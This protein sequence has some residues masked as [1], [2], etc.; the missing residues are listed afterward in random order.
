MKIA[1]CFQQ[2]INNNNKIFL[3]LFVLINLFS[4][5][6]CQLVK[7]EEEENC[8]PKQFKLT[9]HPTLNTSY[10]E[11][12]ENGNLE[13]HDCPDE[14]IFNINILG[15]EEGGRT[16]HG[17]FQSEG[18]IDGQTSLKKQNTNSN[19]TTTNISNQTNNTDEENVLKEP[20]FQA[21]D[22][23]CSGAIPLTKLGAPVMC[24]PSISSCP[25]GFL[26][27]LHQRTG[28]SYCCQASIESIGPEGSSG[29]IPLCSGLQVTF[30][31]TFSGLPKTCSLTS[32]SGCPTG[33]GC[34]L[35]DG[36]FTRC[37][38][39]D[40]GCPANSAGFVHPTTGSHVQ[41]NSADPLSCPNGFIC[42]QSSMFNTGICC[43][44][45]SNAPIDVCGGESPL[46]RPNPCSASDPCPMGYSCRNG[47]CCPSK[48]VCPVGA[49]L[50]G[51]TSCSANGNPCPN[52]FQCVTNNGHQ[53]CCP[54]PEHVCSLPNDSGI[55]CPARVLSPISRFYF[56]S[57][58][59]SCR[60]FQFSQCGGNANNFDSLEQ[61]EGFCLESQCPD[62]GT[63]LRAG[64]SLAR[65]SPGE[66]NGARLADTCPAHYVCV[67]PLFGQHNFVCC[68]SPE[69]VCREPVAA[70][71]PCF[72]PFL[73]IQRFHFNQNKGQCEAFQYYG[74][75]GTGNNFITRSQC[76]MQC[77]PSVQNSC[78]GVAPLNDPGDYVQRCNDNSQC[79]S[80]SWCNQKSYCCPHGETA[81]S[82]QKSIGHT[83]LS[84]RPGT[85]WYY[86]S[87]TDSCLPF[88]YSGCGGTPNRFSEREACEYM[89]LN[90]QENLNNDGGD[91]CPRGMAPLLA[92]GGRGGGRNSKIQS[93]R[94]PLN[95]LN[96]AGSSSYKKCPEGSS[97]VQ[98]INNKNSQKWICCI[99]VAQCP[100]GRNAYLIPNSDS[101]VACVPE[102]LL[103]E[104]GE[105][106]GENFNKNCPSKYSCMQSANVPGFYMCCSSNNYNNVGGGGRSISNT[107]LPS[108]SKIGSFT[109]AV[110]SAVSAAKK[111]AMSSLLANL[112]A[113]QQQ[114]QKHQ[115]HQ[116][117]VLKCPSGLLSNGAK[118]V[119]NQIQACPLGYLCI[120]DNNIASGG[121]G[122]CCK[123]QPK[124]TRK[125]R[126]PVYIA[127]KQVLTCGD[128]EAGCPEGSRC[129]RSTLSGIHICCMP[130]ESSAAVGYT[131]GSSSSSASSSSN[132]DRRTIRRPESSLSSSSSS[133]ASTSFS[134]VP[135]I[136]PKCAKDGALPFFALGSRVPQQCTADRD[137]ECPEEFECEMGTDEQFYCCPAW[138][139]CPAGA[140]PFFVEG[141]RKPLGCN[142]M[143]N[144]CPEGY[145]CEGSKDRAICCRMRANKLQCP[146]GRSPYLYGKRPVVC[147][148]TSN[149]RI[150]PTGFECTPSQNGGGQ[151]LCCSTPENHAPECVAGFGYLDPSTG[152]NQICDPTLETC[153][154]GYRCKRSTLANT[155]VCCSL[156]LDN[157]YDGYCPPGQI[158]LINSGQQLQQEDFI[159]PTNCHQVLNPCP[160]INLIGPPYQCIYSTEKQDSFCCASAVGHQRFG[161][162][163]NNN[164]N[165]ANVAAFP[166]RGESQQQQQQNQQMQ[167][168]LQ[169]QQHW[170]QQ[171]HHRNSATAAQ[172]QAAQA[173]AALQASQVAAAQQQQQQLQQ[174]QQVSSTVQG[175]GGSDGL[176]NNDSLM[177]QQIAAANQMLQLQ[178]QQQNGGV[179][180][181]SY[182]QQSQQ[183]QQQ[184]L[185]QQNIQA[186]QQQ[187]GGGGQYNQQIAQQQ[188]TQQQQQS[189]QPKQSSS[190]SSNNYP[191]SQA[192]ISAAE[193]LASAAL[194]SIYA[195]YGTSK[196]SS[197][198]S[199]S[200]SSSSSLFVA[201]CP[202][203]SRPLL[204]SSTGLGRSCSTWIKC[205]SSFTCYSNFPDGRNAHCCTTVPLD[206]RIVFKANTAAILADEQQQYPH[207]NS[208]YSTQ[209][210]TQNNG[211]LNVSTGVINNGG[212]SIGKCPSNMI[213]IG[214]LCKR[215]FFIGQPGCETDQ[216]CTARSNG[217]VCTRG[218][219]ACPPPLLIHES[220]CVLQCP[221]AM[222]TIAGRCYDLGSI[223]FMDSVDNRENG[224]IGGFCLASVVPEEQCNVKNAY[225][226]EK[227]LT[228]QCTP[229]YELRIDD[230]NNRTEKG[231]CMEVEGS[232]FQGNVSSKRLFDFAHDEEIEEQI[233]NEE[234]IFFKNNKN[235]NIDD[236]P[237][238][239]FF[240]IEFL[241]DL[242]EG[243]EDLNN[244]TSSG[245]KFV[246]ETTTTQ[247]I[248][249]D[250][251]EEDEEEKEEEK[252]DEENKK[253]KKEEEK[254]KE[255]DNEEEKKRM[256]KEEGNDV[257]KEEREDDEEKEDKEEKDG[258][259][260]EKEDKKK[261]G[262]LTE[263]IL[264]IKNIKKDD[265]KQKLL[266]L[267]KVVEKDEET[268]Q[269]QKQ[270]QQEKKQKHLHQ[271]KQQQNNKNTTENKILTKHYDE[272]QILFQSDD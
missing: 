11:C 268:L 70:G 166:S 42:T 86:D 208:Q 193:N 252:E 184:Q 41:C 246:E 100:N 98:S 88:E 16:D 143:A 159:I 39:R 192:A 71:V 109:S 182:Q 199:P 162:Y 17:E 112:N 179:S 236:A 272:K 23:I 34:N 232:R 209:Y 125:G 160:S 5:I 224:T 149:K 99:S 49:P 207:F 154:L 242:V 172:Q 126:K 150:C 251:I 35:V 140:S 173:A 145:T 104:G 171:F 94:Q 170:Q 111:R 102:A 58:T 243:E 153:P 191:Y 66:Q 141:S 18:L 240:E 183:P 121:K 152:R 248:Q 31:E 216:Q 10:F 221:E 127:P 91:E 231:I 95:N 241:N 43:S 128:E 97:C 178:Q 61:C 69:Q 80:G 44:D 6:F 245:S 227:S 195:N 161:N 46:P 77:V 164:N 120:G 197:S 38:G 117:S 196:N 253:V 163:F 201:S 158:P 190:S 28:T 48:G 26:C 139:R 52:N 220:R 239:T 205:P 114:Q 194:H 50:G 269:K 263:K 206:N 67:Q 218:Y 132:S 13:K 63:G 188:L 256:R 144:N 115:Q 76:E 130:R 135:K 211:T 12:N 119:V 47:R 258:K 148:S 65:C 8:N 108:L 110:V 189:Q 133:V 75:G 32:P 202:P 249:I 254:V 51:V 259:R 176:E 90:K 14:K 181:G 122:V 146:N 266:D 244:L 261:G 237:P 19:T 68:S 27:T 107:D 270:Q 175:C 9:K 123:A 225:C 118:C 93:C 138:D 204:D 233:E 79:P 116:Y 25:D 54:S 134:H 73:T 60:T 72:G 235:N 168:W 213:N 234:K 177:A 4:T 174:A 29:N 247:I 151:R 1:K 229:G 187:G 156:P 40:F 30:F 57:T 203:W 257:K 87:D 20:Q 157:R 180:G 210:S 271:Q 3:K 265:E 84:Q 105:E 37:C 89:C 137:D 21:P 53:Y 136:V 22:D 59:G 185:I 64:P 83:C 222:L 165:I 15:C 142:W 212:D 147:H 169:Q 198:S 238:T 217:T 228:C 223:V 56:D 96:G 78:N 264:K 82:S 24:N 226:S 2:N 262:S 214:G 36:A 7:I 219:C 45:T 106:E 250:Q 101:I 33:F 81:C 85:F 131:R 167:Q 186:S 55:Q 124:C 113:A 92:S 103:G 260:E 215:M 129:S 200:P 255:D 62:G 155:H 230:I 74:C 267:L